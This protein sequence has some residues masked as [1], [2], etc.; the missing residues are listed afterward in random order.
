MP[1]VHSISQILYIFQEKIHVNTVTCLM[2]PPTTFF[3][4]LKKKKEKK[5]GS[6]VSFLCN[7][8]GVTHEL[9]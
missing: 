5:E 1:F 7:D 8:I 9:P 6:C 4:S 3:V 2:P